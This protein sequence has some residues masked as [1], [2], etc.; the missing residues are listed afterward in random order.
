VQQRGIDDAENRCRGTD[1]QGNR[2]D[3][4]GGEA[5]RLAQRAQ[6]VAEVLRQRLEQS[7]T[8]RLTAFFFGAIDS[9]K[10][11][12]RAAHGL[13]ARHSSADQILGVGLD[14]KLQLDIHVALHARA[15]ENRP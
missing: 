9:P 12:S 13:L 7:H 6:T 1:A 5:R 11:H 15:P 3:S 8:A 4:D 2:E 10:F 14:V